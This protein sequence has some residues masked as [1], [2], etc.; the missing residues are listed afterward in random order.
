[1]TIKS[2]TANGSKV[3]LVMLPPSCLVETKLNV[4]C[5]VV[6]CAQRGE[7]AGIC[8]PALQDIVRHGTGTDIRIVDIRDFQFATMRWGQSRDDVKDLRI[9]HIDAGDRQVALGV[10][11]LLLDTQDVP[12]LR[13]LGYAKTPWVL[14]LFEENPRTP[15]LA[16]ESFDGWCKV[17]LKDVVPQN[18]AAAI[19]RA[20]TTGQSQR[21]GNA[22]C[23]VLHLVR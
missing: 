1:M 18:D 19:A 12:V 22:A 13:Q 11:R 8:P 10:G 16:L 6:G 2:G 7:S 23:L 15:S 14:H 4:L 3:N 20:E 5:Q 17:I 9:I 21:F